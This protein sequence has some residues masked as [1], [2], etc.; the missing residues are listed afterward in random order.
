MTGGSPVPEGVTSNPFFLLAATS[1]ALVK[2][3]LQG[4]RSPPNALPKPDVLGERCGQKTQHV[5]ADSSVYS[6][7]LIHTIPVT[8]VLSFAGC[9]QSVP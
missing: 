5:I 8:A 9:H 7:I 2:V 3:V 4:F 6:V 1:R